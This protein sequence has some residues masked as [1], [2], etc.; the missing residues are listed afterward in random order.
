[1][2]VC[3]S[4]GC[5]H[6]HSQVNDW[7]G[8]IEVRKAVILVVTIYSEKEYRLKWANEKGAWGRAQEKPG[9]GFQ[10]SS[11]GGVTCTEHHSPSNDGWQHLQTVANKESLPDPWSLG[12]LLEVDH[13]SMECTHNWP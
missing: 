11:P 1:M 4:Y 12:I 9:T 6:I 7:L 5:L 3:I 13:R 2:D 10:L 8:L